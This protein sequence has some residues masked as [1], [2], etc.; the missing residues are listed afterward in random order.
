LVG[1]CH[2]KFEYYF[3][4]ELSYISLISHGAG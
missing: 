1:R 4:F 2:I 3:D